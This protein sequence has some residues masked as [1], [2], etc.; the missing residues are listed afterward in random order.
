VD[1][2]DPRATRHALALVIAAQLGE[3]AVQV[4]WAGVHLDLPVAHRPLIARPVAVE[5]DAVP[6]RV[7]GVERLA[8]QVVGGPAQPPAGLGDPLQR[9]RQVGPARHQDRQVEQPTGAAGPGRSIGV[10]DQLDDRRLSRIDPEAD[11]SV[12]PP[13]LGEA[14]RLR[15]EARQPIE[16]RDGQPNRAHAGCRVDRAVLAHESDYPA[17]ASRIPGSG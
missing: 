4:E 11:D 5:L 9:P 15:V 17:A 16:V 7:A 6:L 8:H 3:H 14:D 12:L 1:V 2:A 10:A 13:E